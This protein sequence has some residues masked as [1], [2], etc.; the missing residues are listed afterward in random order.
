MELATQ[1]MDPV[2]MADIAAAPKCCKIII[3]ID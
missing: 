3:I 2:R 1:V